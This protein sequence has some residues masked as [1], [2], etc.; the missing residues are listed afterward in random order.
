MSHSIHTVKSLRQN[1]FLVRVKHERKYRVASFETLLHFAR[2]SVKNRSS[3]AVCDVKEIP[4]IKLQL[5][6]KGGRTTVD[7]TKD[8][9]THSGIA[10]CSE[11]DHWNRKRSLQ[12]SIARAMK[13]FF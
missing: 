11:R 6:S 5:L 12:I 1:G 9:I 10:E 4:E 3:I 7:I 8:G 13:Q 2:K